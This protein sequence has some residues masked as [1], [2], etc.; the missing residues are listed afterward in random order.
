MNKEGIFR[1][2]DISF[3][4]QLVDTLEEARLKLEEAYKKRDYE[5]FDKSKKF[6][7]Q[8]QKKISEVIK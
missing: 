4:N 6:I 7:I 5:N 3:L 2:E 1:E 8:L